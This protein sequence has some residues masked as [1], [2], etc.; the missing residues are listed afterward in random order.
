MDLNV[1]DE[2]SLVPDIEGV[3]DDAGSRYVYRAVVRYDLNTASG[4]DASTMHWAHA[5]H[6]EL[7][8]GGPVEDATVPMIQSPV[9]S[10]MTALVGDSWKFAV[11]TLRQ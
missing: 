7:L 2:A 5:H 10:Y 9:K 4:S 6:M 8:P 3:V 1:R 11:A